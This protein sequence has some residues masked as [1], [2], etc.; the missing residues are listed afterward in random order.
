MC[1]SQ[2]YHWYTAT[3][4]SICILSTRFYT[5]KSA[6]RLGSYLLSIISE[7]WDGV[8][9]STFYFDRSNGWIVSSQK[10][11]RIMLLVRMQSMS[12]WSGSKCW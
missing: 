9:F 10:E 2:E 6:S 8:S 1:S 11:I 4:R 5:S 12:D 3:H 7:F